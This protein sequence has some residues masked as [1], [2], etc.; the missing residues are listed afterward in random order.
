MPDRIPTAIMTRWTSESLGTTFTGGLWS[1]ITP[2]NP[3]FPYVIMDILA[4]TIGRRASGGLEMP[5]AAVRFRIFWKEPGDGSTDPVS[6]VGTLQRALKSSY[7]WAPLT[8]TGRTN[9]TVKFTGA[10]PAR[11]Y[12][13][14]RRI[15]VGVVEYEI[16]TQRTVTCNPS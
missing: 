9:F 5:I 13:R 14:D 11:V 3:T 12:D 15:W 6:A 1:G 16:T 8:Y 4:E 10:P 2:S 7:D